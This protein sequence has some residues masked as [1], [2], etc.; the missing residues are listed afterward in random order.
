MVKIATHASL[1]GNVENSAEEQE[2]PFDFGVDAVYQ[3]KSV[4]ESDDESIASSTNS[5]FF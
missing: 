1:T 5:D 2:E 3:K 4:E